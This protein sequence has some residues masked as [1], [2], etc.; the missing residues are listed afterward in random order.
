MNYVQELK[1]KRKEMQHRITDLLHLLGHEENF[2]V[3]PSECEHIKKHNIKALVSWEA[4]QDDQYIYVVQGDNF[5][6]LWLMEL[7]EL[8]AIADYLDKHLI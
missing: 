5:K 6:V 4:T 2:L 1:D 8:A 3:R 7:E